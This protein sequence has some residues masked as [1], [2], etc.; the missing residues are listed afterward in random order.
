MSQRNP[1]ELECTKYAAAFTTNGG[2]RTAAFREV[3]RNSK[4]QPE[5]LNQQASKFHKLPKV[6]TRIHGIHIS[7]N[8]GANDRALFTAEQALNEFEQA[9]QLAKKLGQPAAMCAATNGKVKVAGLENMTIDIKT[10][11]KPPRT[12]ADFYSS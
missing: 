3:F 6:R 4:A 1:T 5:T 2:D 9:R 7:I 12:L 8:G 11:P 10:E